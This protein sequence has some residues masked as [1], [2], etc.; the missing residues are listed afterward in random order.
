MRFGSCVGLFF[1]PRKKKVL[2]WKMA[3]KEA[4]KH[5]RERRG[6]MLMM[7]AD[8]PVKHLCVCVCVVVVVVVDP[9]FNQTI[10]F[11]FYIFFFLCCVSPGVDSKT[12]LRGEPL[13]SGVD[14]KSHLKDCH[15]RV[16]LFLVLPECT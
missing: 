13:K 7:M 9:F 5:H 3:G 11:M 6:A 10:V 4:G 8:L 1:L 12:V 15:C 16:N 2:L 14:V